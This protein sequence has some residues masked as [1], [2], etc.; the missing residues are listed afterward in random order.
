MLNIR[1]C[2]LMLS[3]LTALVLSA[4]ARAEVHEGPMSTQKIA[5]GSGGGGPTGVQVLNEFHM[6]HIDG[7]RGA[8]RV[9]ISTFNVAFPNEKLQSAETSTSFKVG[10]ITSIGTHFTRQISQT[11]SARQHTVIQGIDAAT[12]QRIADAAYADFVE[13]LTRSGYEV[14]GP[15]ELAKLAPEFAT[16]T[17]QPNFTRGRY[18]AYVAPTGRKLFLLRSDTAKPTSQGN[19][20]QMAAAFQGLDSPQAF[21]RSPYLAHDANLGIIAV[22]LVVDYGTYVN[23]GDTKRF[24]AEMAVGFTAGVTVQGG[25]FYDTATLL[26]YWGPKSGG[27]PAIAALAAPLTSDLAFAAVNNG[28][29]GE[30][31]VDVKADPALFATAAGEA[32]QAANTKL[33]AALS[34]AAAR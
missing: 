2:A 31:E 10:G 28:G 30:G 20:G 23:T 26:D 16:W 22:T 9:A 4:P 25:S 17:A 33:V 3:G 12:R 7:F 11:K 21:A 13:R 18:G 24:N 27:F 8:K 34:A 19:I 6:V 29:N 1:S 14:V 15:D 5:L 32:T